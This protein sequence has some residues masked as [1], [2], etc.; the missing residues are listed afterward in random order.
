MRGLFSCQSPKVFIFKKMHLFIMQTFFSLETQPAL[1]A[2]IAIV[3]VVVAV[4]ITVLIL[5]IRRRGCKFIS[6]FWEH[7]TLLKHLHIIRYWLIRDFFFLEF[8]SHLTVVTSKKC[9]FWILKFLVQLTV[10]RIPE[11]RPF[12]CQEGCYHW[13]RASFNVL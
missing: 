5:V 12:V 2:V 6:L 4:V 9:L 7:F 1:I 3:I 11:K 13:H 10:L 8:I